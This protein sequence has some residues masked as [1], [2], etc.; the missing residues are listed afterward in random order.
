M[1]LYPLGTPVLIPVYVYN[2]A[3]PPVLV[4]V[5]PV[6]NVTLIK[7]DRTSSVLPTV[8]DP[9]A[10]G[11]YNLN[12]QPSTLNQVGPYRVIPTVTG[13]NAGTDFDVFQVFDPAAFPRLVSFADAKRVVK[14]LGTEDDAL[15][16]RI[17]G[18]ASAR[19]VIEY[20]GGLATV[21]QR[22]NVRGFDPFFKLSTTPVN[23][24]TSV[25]NAIT[26]ITVDT[27][28]LK[29]THPNAG[30][31]SFPSGAVSG[32]NDVVYEAGTTEIP[33]GLDAAVLTLIRHWW[34]VLVVKQT[35]GGYGGGSATNLTP[36]FAGLPNTVTNMLA[37]LPR[38]QGFA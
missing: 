24:I 12:L 11:T 38:P 31:V 1:D 34:N 37:A 15:L 20:Q 27:T 6:P 4:D 7:P 22:V 13:A 36:D 14:A 16:D 2:T 35:V 32:P 18:W 10:V 28:L 8:D 3:V 23:S 19:I 26:G 21:T 29:I 9:S 30:L 33:P 17:I 25:T 5:S